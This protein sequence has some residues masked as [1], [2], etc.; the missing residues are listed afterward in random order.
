VL[1]GQATTQWRGDPSELR[2]QRRG[3]QL[4]A[5]GC[6]QGD[7]VSPPDA[8]VVEEVRVP[9][10]VGQQFGEG[11]PVRFPPVRGVG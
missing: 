8:E 11:A 3:D 7:R 2:G 9:V 1:P 4:G 10:D 6:H 5:V